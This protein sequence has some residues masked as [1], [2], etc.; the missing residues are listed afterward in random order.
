M[1]RG[2][3]GG[4]ERARGPG[5]PVEG[6][7]LRAGAH[8]GAAGPRARRAGDPRR[9]AA[10]RP[11]AWRSSR[12]AR[13][14]PR[15]DRDQPRGD[16][17][18]RHAAGAAARPADVPRPGWSRRSSTCRSCC[19]RRSPGSR[20]CSCSGG[21]GSSASRCRCSGSRSRSPTIAVVI[22]Q[23]FVSAPFFIRSARTGFASVDRDLEDAARVD[24]ATE[25]QLF[26]RSRCRSRRR[27]SPPAW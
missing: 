22:A 1:T 24:G 21:A 18:A 17:R 27:R 13:A 15:H 11:R 19:R 12:R 26:R 2:G 3:P 4:T 25:R 14:Q 8:P 5:R 7:A 10:R 9:C 20:C 6:L 16:G 23:T